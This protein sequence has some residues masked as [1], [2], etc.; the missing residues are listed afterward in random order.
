MKRD[1]DLPEYLVEHNERVTKVANAVDTLA[2]CVCIKNADHWTPL[3]GDEDWTAAFAAEERARLAREAKAGIEA[4]EEAMQVLTVKAME[5]G[6]ISETGEWYHKVY[7]NAQAYR[8][9]LATEM[10]EG[11]RMT[12]PPKRRKV[13]SGR[14]TT[15]Q[16]Q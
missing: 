7:D 14:Y 15:K 16:E 13:K 10:F 5:I 9:Q 8:V 1:N 12:P 4:L 6:L 11:L 2:E 3:D